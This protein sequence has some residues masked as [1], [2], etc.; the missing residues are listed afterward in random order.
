MVTGNEAGDEHKKRRALPTLKLP[1]PGRRLEIGNVSL[2]PQTL[3]QYRI[4]L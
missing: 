2:L 4:S 1:N 3:Y